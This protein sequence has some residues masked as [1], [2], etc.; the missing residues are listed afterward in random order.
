MSI[1]STTRPA[2]THQAA[3]AL[4]LTHDAA[5]VALEG[6]A[7]AFDD[8]LELFERLLEDDLVAV[9]AVAH[10]FEDRFHLI[11]EHRVHALAG[12][13]RVAQFRELVEQ[14]QG[15]MQGRRRGIEEFRILGGELPVGHLQIA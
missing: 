7:L 6:P 11:A 12:V 15:R 13:R 5:H 8:G 3:G 1:S 10:T 4:G 2:R 9:V 14:L